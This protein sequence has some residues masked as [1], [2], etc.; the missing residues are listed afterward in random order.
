M[1]NFM[2]KRKIKII[3]FK[4][5]FKEIKLENSI[6]KN[7][8]IMLLKNFAFMVFPLITFPYLSRVFGPSGMGKINF[9]SSF[10]NYFAM[11]ATL[12]LPMYGSREIAKVRDDKDKLSKVYKELLVISVISSITVF[13]I[14]YITI[15]TFPKSKEQLLFFSLYGLGFITNALCVEW[16]FVGIEKF[17]YVSIRAIIM[18]IIFIIMTFIFVKSEK[19][20]ILIPL[21][22]LINGVIQICLNINYSRKYI[23]YSIKYQLDLSTHIKPILVIFLGTIASA[24]FI[25]LDIVMLGIMKSDWNVGIYNASVR[26]VSIAIG[27]MTS[28]SSIFYSRLS[29]YYAKGKKEDSSIV[30]ENWIKF[31]SI[32]IFP[33][34]VGLLITAKDIVLILAGEQYREAIVTSYIMIP[35]LFFSVINNYYGVQLYSNGKEKQ[36]TIIIILSLILSIS[37]NLVMIPKFSENGAAI[38]KVT[39]GFFGFILHI[40]FI[41]K[42]KLTICFVKIKYFLFSLLMGIA[43]YVIRR[44]T[45]Y[46]LIGEFLITVTSGCL[47]YGLIL[48]LNRDISLKNIVK[49]K[50]GVENA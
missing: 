25:N 17:I 45:N 18:Q 48:I 22:L 26:I 20:F 7:S 42:N 27:I 5:Y 32:L 8:V 49:S 35:V 30:L 4:E 21:F 28:I 10:A 29:N 14:F 16:F 43:L 41:K 12:G 38:S 44:I 11:F 33:M 36:A 19:D 6:K 40:Y 47:I 31:I 1:I 3:I 50:I 23:S 9:A 24:I 46:S 37:L 15:Y 34:I 2:Y 39:I 13:S